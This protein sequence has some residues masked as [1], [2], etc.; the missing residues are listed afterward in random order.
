MPTQ[1]GPGA[2]P[3]IPFLPGTTPSAPTTR[4]ADAALAAAFE[5]FWTAYPRSENKAGARKLWPAAV[6]AAGS[7]EVVVEG[8]KRYAADPNREQ[9]YTAH[10]TTWLRA[11]RW[12]DPPLPPRPGR[13]QA[14]PRPVDTDREAP[15]GRLEL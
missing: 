15:S 4:A 13:G 12:N 5:Q 8:A 10:A 7:T 3:I 9:A 2:P 1:G 11:E 6:K 14:A